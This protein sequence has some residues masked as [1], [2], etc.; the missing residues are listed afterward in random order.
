MF[1]QQTGGFQGRGAQVFKLRRFEFQAQSHGTAHRALR[2]LG[3]PTQRSRRIAVVQGPLGGQQLGTFA[4]FLRSF[5]VVVFQ[6]LLQVLVTRRFV[7]QGVRTLGRHDV[8]QRPQLG[9]VGRSVVVVAH[10]MVDGLIQAQGRHGGFTRPNV[11]PRHEVGLRVEQLRVQGP[12]FLQGT[13]A[14]RLHRQGEQQRHGAQSHVDQHE[15]RD[16]DQQHKV[17]RQ[18]NAVR[19]PKDGHRGVV[20][21]CK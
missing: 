19:G 18:I 4:G 1:G 13:P 6:R 10:R 7:L 17:E 16:Q 2:Q 20:V 12:L 14:L 21:A 8:G 15:C 5:G 11:T 9:G 3:Q